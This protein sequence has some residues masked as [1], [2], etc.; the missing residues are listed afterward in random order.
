MTVERDG[1]FDVSVHKILDEELLRPETI[2]GCLVSIPGTAYS[3]RE[4]TMYF[5]GKGKKR[6]IRNR[7]LYVFAVC[8]AEFPPTPVSL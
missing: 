4:E 1:L 6:F 3:I 2:F 8:G 7:V 5:P